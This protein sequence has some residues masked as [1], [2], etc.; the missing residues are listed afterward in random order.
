MVLAGKNFQA[1]HKRLPP[2]GGSWWPREERMDSPSTHNS[3]ELRIFLRCPSVNS[4]LSIACNIE[5]MKAASNDGVTEN[6]TVGTH[7]RA[8]CTGDRYFLRRF[9]T[10]SVVS[11]ADH[12]VTY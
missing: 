12:I 1:R 4:I 8:F 10:H 2:S 7:N 9:V 5:P 6:A 11:W 3:R